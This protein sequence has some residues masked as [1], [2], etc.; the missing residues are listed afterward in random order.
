MSDFLYERDGAIY[1]PTQ[2]AGGPWSRTA[3]HGGPVNA[4]LMRAARSA[5]EPA[6]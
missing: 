1:T 2:W 6:P 3:Q 5:A 4:L